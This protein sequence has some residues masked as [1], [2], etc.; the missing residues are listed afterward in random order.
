M[1][2]AWKQDDTRPEQGYAKF[3]NDR[4]VSNPALEENIY[5]DTEIKEAERDVENGLE[6]WLKTETS[7]SKL[8]EATSVHKPSLFEPVHSD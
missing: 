4:D 7:F 2:C 5:G 3:I 6:D 8:Q 1:V